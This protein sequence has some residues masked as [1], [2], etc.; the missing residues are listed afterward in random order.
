MHHH[1]KNQPS[2]RRFTLHTPPKA[3]AL[4]AVAAFTCSARAGEVGAYPYMIQWPDGDINLGTYTKAGGGAVS[5][6]AAGNG[7]KSYGSASFHG[8]A[9]LGTAT[10]DGTGPN[11]PSSNGRVGGGAYWFEQITISSPTVPVGTIG[12]ADF[13]L[14]FEGD[15]SAGPSHPNQSGSYGA[16]ISYNWA[17]IADGAD[18]VADPNVGDRY[19]E[20]ITVFSGYSETIGGNFRNQPRH[21]QVTFR[22]GQPFDFTVA[23]TSRGSIWRN[24]PSKADAQIRLTGWNGFRNVQIRNGPAVTDS[25]ISS[26]S[27]FNYANAGST[28]YSQ[29]ASLYQLPAASP[30]ADTNNNG[31][32]DQMEYALGRNPRET[33]TGSPHTRG[34]MRLGGQDYSCFSFTRPRLGARASEIT[35]LP[36]CSDGLSGW[37][38]TG[39]ETTVAPS[40]TQTEIVTVRSTQPMGAQTREFLRLG[41]A[42]P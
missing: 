34:V 31:L 19:S 37:T 9:A 41:V 14:F 23:V 15:L 33:D 40:T 3:A 36:Q 16:S 10:G 13:T 28:T 18:N 32:T 11:S 42:K 1:S 38:T 25:S 29:W 5:P 7:W 26:Q 2:R 8:L 27:G 35:Y 30:L 22:F 20:S 21:H 4:L 24:T 39:L 6:A 12:T 17:G